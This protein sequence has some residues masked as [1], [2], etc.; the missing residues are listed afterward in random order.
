[1]SAPDL[2]SLLRHRACEQP[3]ATAYI[4][5][6]GTGEQ[7]PVTYAWLDARARAV[8]AA[9][10]GCGVEPGERALLMFAPGPD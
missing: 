2:V 6:D 10:A 9:I 7:R 1:M 3:D 4:F 8:A 5:D